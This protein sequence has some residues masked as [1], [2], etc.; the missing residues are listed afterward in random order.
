MSR[1]SVEE[2]TPG[3]TV[4]GAVRLLSIALLLLLVA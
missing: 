1:R 3:E 4:S 2:V